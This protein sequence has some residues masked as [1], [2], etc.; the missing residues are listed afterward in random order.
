MIDRPR[1]APHSA[2]AI[3]VLA[4]L[5][6]PALGADRA[7]V[8]S[9]D[10][11][12]GYYSGLDLAPP[13]ATDVDIEATCSD[14]AVRVRGDHLYILGRFGCDFVQV[15]DP[16]T[17]ATVRQFTT[18]AGTNPQD[19][20]V[21]APNKAYVTLYER[22]EILIVNP[23][24]GM[25]TGVI[26]LGV[27]ADADGLPE[28][29]GL[30]QVGDRV[31]VALQR[32]DRPGGFVA[33]NPSFL[34]VLDATN[35]GIVDVD[36]VAPGLQ[37]IVLTGRNPFADLSVDPVR[38]KL[39]VGEA[40]VFGALDGGVEFVDPVTLT[41]EGFFVTEAELGGD[42]NAVKLWVDCNGYAIVN[43]ATFRTKLVRFD[44][45]TGTVL[46]T[47]WQSAGYDLYDLEIDHRRA[48]VLVS[49]RDLVTPGVRIFAA[50][51]CTQITTSPIGF[52][53]PPGEIALAE[54]PTPTDAVPAPA[55]LVLAN[56]P[57]PFNPTTTLH[58]AVPPGVRVRV[59][60]AD[61][62]GR[63]VRR[64]WEGTPGASGRSLVWDGRDDGGG[65][66]PSGVYWARAT[67]A[68]VATADRMTL[69]R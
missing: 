33:T 22:D 48:H 36:P 17:L 8:L 40:G 3:A 29:A 53:L 18:G 42:L 9:T 52:G 61:V 57:D 60:I 37:A 54:E 23:Q 66:L 5:A 41:A 20:V 43:D 7:L 25:H 65:A 51:S 1:P 68:G 47:C 63:I 28:A 39:V 45:C 38:G 59:E 2:A 13:F 21:V 69:V 27:F 56:H 15:V 19:I 35:D 24:T 46:G 16:V 34:A 58:V 6:S 4:A 26:D 49:D 14:A 44:R 62:R 55:R 30:A 11:A 12:T 10:F 50:G 32:L 31:F 67:G 64:L